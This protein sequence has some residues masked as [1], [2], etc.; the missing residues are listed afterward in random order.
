MMALSYDETRDYTEFVDVKLKDADLNTIT[1]RILRS[2][3]ETRFQ[4]D[5]AHLQQ[6]VDTLIMD[7][8]NIALAAKF[9]INAPTAEQLEAEKLF[10]E[11][12]TYK[13]KTPP[14][15][16][17]TKFVAHPSDRASQLFSVLPQ[18]VLSLI[19]E[20]MRYES[21]RYWLIKSEFPH[22]KALR[23]S[24][25]R[26]AYDPRM[27]SILFYGIRLVATP[28][29]FDLLEKTSIAKV[30]PYVHR[31][32]FF[33][34]FESWTLKFD[35]F[36]EIIVSQAIQ[37]YCEDHNIWMGGGSFAMEENGVEKF[38]K[39]YWTGN[40]PFSD[41]EVAAGYRRYKSLAAAGKDL[42]ES[43][44]LVSKWTGVLR[45]LPKCR[46]FRIDSQECNG[47]AND[48]PEKV[49]FNI[50]KHHHDSLHGEGLC[51]QIAGV[52]GEK[53]FEVA[54]S[55]LAQSNVQPKGL[56]LKFRCTGT[57]NWASLPHWTKLD[58]SKLA[59]LT[60]R[61]VAQALGEASP[62]PQAEEL[63]LDDRAC[64]ALDSVLRKCKRSITELVIEKEFPMTW[65]RDELVA[66]P[67]LRK[68][69]LG[70]ICVNN[71]NFAKLLP[72]M[73]KLE[74]YSLGCSSGTEE[75]KQTI[76]AIRDHPNR[77][78]IHWDQIACHSCAEISLY[79][80]TANVSND[81][82]DNDPW[83]D[84]GR[85]LQNY[86]AGKGR[87]NKCLRMWFEDED[88]D[89]TGSGEEWSQHGSEDE[90]DDADDEE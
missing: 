20:Q 31:L 7:R 38:I 29:Y 67:E 15:D 16:E 10:F 28:Q 51:R 58:L 9:G 81:D 43:G 49:D 76:D 24:C 64:A 39:H 22:L 23:L 86:L 84:S 82:K 37:R 4:K 70:S 25:S 6:A 71:G 50:H 69:D 44:R 79:C 8:F 30:A 21:S 26:F 3:L 83:M 59:K 85:S 13:P 42:M 72:L 46:Q 19:L 57:F 68:I 34:P 53:L 66:L 33:P 52:L 90:D 88:P 35:E 87:W 62:W 56:D 65:P 45:A 2:S 78:E 77:M 32:T 36:K 73:P 61:P 1:T 74:R 47:H 60:F 18:E 5:L 80:N 63:A 54:V 11:M 41:N 27:M 48:I 40:L 55:C 75:W 17:T 14:M 89:D 12:K